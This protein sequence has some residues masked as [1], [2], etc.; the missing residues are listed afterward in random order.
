MRR[1]VPRQPLH[2]LHDLLHLHRRVPQAQ[3]DG[4]PGHA[5]GPEL[6]G[7]SS[8]SSLPKTWRR[9]PDG[10]PACLPGL[11]LLPGA[12]PLA[13]RLADSPRRCLLPRP[14]PP[15]PLQYAGEMKKGVFSLMNYVLPKMGILSLHSGCNEG[16][17][18]DVTLF[19]GLS[20]GWVLLWVLC[21]GW[22]LIR[23]LLLCGAVGG[24]AG[25]SRRAGRGRAD[26]DGQD[27]SRCRLPTCGLDCAAAAS[28]VAPPCSSAFPPRPLAC[29]P[30]RQAPARPLCPRTPTAP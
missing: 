27:A 19:F 15:L 8:M 16:K 6:C 5:G 22:H 21:C 12:C 1:R 13:T 9:C 2:L 18:G 17:G 14:A 7:S 11:P 30:G 3:G 23:A 28:P 25:G 4:H 20:G 26:R 10:L 24:V 29:S